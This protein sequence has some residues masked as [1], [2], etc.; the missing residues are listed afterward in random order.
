MASRDTPRPVPDY[1]ICY[2]RNRPKTRHPALALIGCADLADE[3]IAQLVWLAGADRVTIGVAPRRAGPFR[4][5]PRPSEIELRVRDEFVAKRHAVLERRPDGWWLLDAGSRHGTFAAGKR[6]AKHRLRP[7]DVFETGRT[8]WR[9]LEHAW[10]AAPPASVEAAELGPTR[11]ICPRLIEELCWTRQLAPSISPVIILGESGVGKD[12]LARQI[13]AWS[14]RKGFFKAVNCAALDEKE[15][16]GCA[17]GS[18]AKAARDM[19][20]QIDAATEGTLLLDQIDELPPVTQA[21]LIGVL[22][23]G[24]FHRLGE[25]RPRAVSA[26]FIATIMT[27]DFGWLMS[28]GKLREDLYARFVHAV[29]LVPLRERVEDL[30]ILLSHVLRSSTGLRPRISRLDPAAFRRLLA[31]SWPLNVR[32]FECRVRQALRVAGGSPVLSLEH[33]ALPTEIPRKARPPDRKRP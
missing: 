4:K 8:F 15:L 22:E 25:S 28:E 24:E 31:Y 5:N 21:K 1:T 10:L 7:G 17:T 19:G 30:G 18:M 29:R 12:V 2:V 20:G 9:Y 33:L 27:P 23:A 32:E 3:D 6:R 16:F 26:R 11:T 14:G 13:H